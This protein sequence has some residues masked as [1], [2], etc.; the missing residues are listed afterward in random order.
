MHVIGMGQKPD[1]STMTMKDFA[2][3][4][5]ASPL[6]PYPLKD[7]IS[8]PSAGYT[9]VRFK[10]TNPGFWLFHCHFGD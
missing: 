6:K 7:T 9:I 10:A 4:A 1:N 8:I 3:N 2:S 5:K